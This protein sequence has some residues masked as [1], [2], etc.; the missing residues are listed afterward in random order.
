MK[1]NVMTFLSMKHLMAYHYYIYDFSNRYFCW[2]LICTV[3]HHF[4]ILYSYKIMILMPSNFCIIW[5]VIQETGTDCFSRAPGF[6][7]CFQ[8]GL[9]CSLVQFSGGG[10]CVFFILVCLCLMSCV[11]NVASFSGLSILNCPF[12][13]L[14]RLFTCDDKCTFLV[15]C[16][17]FQYIRLVILHIRFHIWP[18][19]SLEIFDSTIL[20]RLP[21]F[22]YDI[23]IIGNSIFTIT[24]KPERERQIYD[25][26]PESLI[27]NAIVTQWIPIINV[28]SS[29]NI[30]K[31]QLRTCS[32]E[33][34]HSFILS[35]EGLKKKYDKQY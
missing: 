13:F 26:K 22:R 4:S 18:Y 23:N 2:L 29:T 7:S 20:P 11:P 19:F 34:S 30:P 32:N 1:D 8:W 15:I 3:V 35:T 27:N 24:R 33:W 10:G 28:I 16:F 5:G 25:R 21:C 17:I 6:I 12:H 14:K 9:C 31:I